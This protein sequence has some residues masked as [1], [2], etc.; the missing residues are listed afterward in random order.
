MTRLTT[1]ILTFFLLIGQVQAAERV[2][3]LQDALQ[4]AEQNDPGLSKAKLEVEAGDARV[5]EAYSAAMPRLNAEAMFMRY[6]VLPKMYLEFP[7][8]PPMWITMGQNHSMTADITLTQPIWLAGKVGLALDAAKTY[9]KLARSLETT[10]RS[11]LKANVIKEYYGVQLAREML[12]VTKEAQEQAKRHTTIVEQMF[13][14]GMASEF[15]LLQAQVGL[16]TIEP[17]VARAEQAVRLAELA[18]INRLGLDPG[19]EINL[20]EKLTDIQPDGWQAPAGDPLDIARKKRSEFD[21]M[22]LQKDLYTISMKVNQRSL[23]LPSFFFVTNYHREASQDKFDL[24]G[25]VWTERFNWLVQVSVPIFDGLATPAKVQQDKIM[26]RKIEVDR[27]QLEQGVRLQVT[28]T[29]TEL[30][31]AADQARS[32]KATVDLAERAHSIAQTRFEQG[33]GTETDVQDAR[34]ALQNARL[35]YLK[36]IYDLRVAQAE[37]A[38]VVENDTNFSKVQ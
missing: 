4:L 16:G 30:K 19:T 14:A 13:T 24:G 10:N 36:G 11:Q 31:R 2:L 22:D 29:L 23:Y 25:S 1:I 27:L 34:I 18:F 26:L 32:S 6:M 38:M 5:K 12:T 7:G 37:Y 3:T 9:S 20:A 21:M 17:E 35:G 33:V 8:A 28:A 15:A